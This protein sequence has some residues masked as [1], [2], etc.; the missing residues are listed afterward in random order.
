VRADGERLAMEQIA[1]LRSH[2]HRLEVTAQ[3]APVIGLLGMVLGMIAALKTHQ[4]AGPNRD[5]AA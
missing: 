3:A 5:P 2:L 1:D 4:D